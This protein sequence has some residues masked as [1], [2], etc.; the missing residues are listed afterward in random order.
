MTI[1]YRAD[2]LIDGVSDEIIED[3]AVLVENGRIV[4][5]G[6]DEE[7]SGATENRGPWGRDSPARTHRRPRASSMECLRRT[8]L[9]RRERASGSHG[10]TVRG[11]HEEASRRWC[12]DRAGR[13]LYR[14]DG[15]RHRPGG[16]ARCFCPVP[17]LLLPGR[18]IAMTGGHGWFLGQEADG[19]DAV[20]SAV[21]QEIKNGATCI[22]FYG[23]GRSVR[24]RG[25][26][27]LPAAH[28]GR[29]GCRGRGGSQS[30]EKSCRPCLLGE[31]NK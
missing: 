9:A 1:A 10:P 11:E 24:A 8:P 15:Y 23:I 19:P 12:D 7:V 17:G 26:A 18:A 13:R 31:G 14:R 22:K 2:R 29:D 4:S 25:R 5:V 27:W 16:T 28:R 3:A 30:G 21:R 20:R 6:P